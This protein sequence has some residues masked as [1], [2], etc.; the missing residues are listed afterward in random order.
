[1]PRRVLRP[2]VLLIVLVSAPALTAFEIKVAQLRVFSSRVTATLALQDL[3]RDRFLEIVQQG[4]AVFVQVQADLWED[5]RVA[6][7][8]AL[9]TPAL[10]YRVDRGAERG[11]VITDQY[12]NRSNHEDLRAPLPVRL[13][14]GP[15]TSLA[16][17]RAYYLRAQ[18]TA[19]TV[20][21]R[22]IDQVGAAIF[23]DDQS[24][25]GL[26]SLGRYVFRTLLRIGRYLDSAS[27]EATSDRYTGLQIKSNRN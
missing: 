5:R 20:A 15:A 14:L 25:V 11:V 1:M 26:A 13:D 12:G 17:D 21:D 3:L 27:A 6:D 2:V 16:D 18:V 22:E 4:S 19:A 9:T 10:Q 8:L 24:A 23:G 7:R